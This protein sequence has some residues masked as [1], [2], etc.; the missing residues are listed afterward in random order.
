MVVGMVP[1]RPCRGEQ[2]GKQPKGAASAVAVASRGRLPGRIP[3]IKVGF[4][5]FVW[6]FFYCGSK[7]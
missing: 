1:V 6:W 4:G 2:S 5:E 7:D 3:E